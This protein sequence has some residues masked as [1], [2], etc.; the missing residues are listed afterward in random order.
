MML[1][2]M[3]LLAFLEVRTGVVVDGALLEGL[4]GILLTHA[5]LGVLRVV[6]TVVAQWLL[7]SSTGHF[8]G[9]EPGDGVAEEFARGRGRATRA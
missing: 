1:H 4:C 7:L 6:P 8:K 2:A 9:S 3:I 5:V